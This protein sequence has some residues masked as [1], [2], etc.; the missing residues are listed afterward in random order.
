MRENPDAVMMFAAGFGTRMKSLTRDKPKPLIPVAGKP[1]VDHALDLAA[2]IEPT[3]IVANLHYRPEILQQH[4]TK[5]GVITVL[6]TPDILETGG[7]LRN[8]MP[9]LGSGPVYTMNT[10]A[11]WAG[12]NPLV[13]LRDAW[14]PGKMDGLLMLVPLGN[15][16]GHTGS[17]DFIPD[18]SGRLTRGPGQIYGGIQIIK[19]ERLSEI[20]Q[21]KFSLNK[22][23]D[24]MLADGRLHGISYPGK[25]CD[26]G[27]PEGIALAEQ[28][29][30]E[31]SV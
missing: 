21:Q 23:W 17:G 1:L 18:L 27:Q 14:D 12:P 19:T 25:W 30:D 7:G 10:D 2:G 4:L 8:A 20:G 13:L 26:V 6:E 5:R 29:L 28:L 31:T 3:C 24:L 16:V 22:L 9:Y 11:I 15:A